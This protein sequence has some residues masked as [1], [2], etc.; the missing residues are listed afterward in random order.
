MLA[1]LPGP[2]GLAQL[3]GLGAALLALEGCTSPIPPGRSAVDAVEVHDA[4]GVAPDETTSKL[5]TAATPR[6]LGLFHAVY[7]YAIFDPATLQRDLARVER[8]YRGRGF[9]EAHARTARVIQ[10][11]S[12]H[13]RV[14]IVV[15]EGPP[16]LDR[17]VRVLGLDDVPADVKAAAESAATTALPAGTRFD[18]QAFASA[19]TAV[20][21]A[22]TD[23]GYAYAKVEAAAQVDLAAH[24]ADFTFTA[25]AGRACVFGPIAFVGLDPDGPGGAPPVI[26]EP[27]L[28]RAVHIREGATYSTAAIESATQALLDLEVLSAVEIVPTLADPPA[29]VVPLTVKVQPS[30]L[31]L[32]KAGAGFELDEIKTEVHALVGWEDHDFLGDLRDFSIDFKPGVVLYPTRVDNLVSPTNPLPAERLRLQLRQPGFLEPR[33]TLFVRPELNVYPLLVEPNPDPNQPVVGY[34]E[35]RGAVGVDRRFGKHFVA[36][37]SHNVQGEYPFAYIPSLPIA[38]PLPQ[39]LLSYP[40]LLTTFD[41][42]DDPVHP[43]AGL[44]AS[45]DLQVAG[46]GGSASDIRIQ[47]ELRGYVPLARSVTLALRGSLGL[48]FAQN[49]GD[50]VQHHL[51]EPAAPSPLPGAASRTYADVDRDIEIVYFRGFFSGGPS[52]NRGFPLRGIAPHGRVPFLNPASASAQVA[53]ACAPGQPG[54]DTPRCSVPIGGFTLWEGSIESRFDISGP[55]GAALF[56]DAGDVSAESLDFR[57]T[58]L[59]LSCGLGARYDTPVGPIRLD[60]GYR[61]PFLQVLGYATE[62]DVAAHDPTEGTQ[63]AIFGVP[64]ALAFGIGEAF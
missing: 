52:S 18:E 4:H 56:C 55:L 9:L 2:R 31:R 14:E 6:F 53:L 8:S 47:P 49:Y 33:S 63:P 23:H 20:S 7:D 64:L 38:E 17:T 21:R 54:Y 40:Q 44:Y 42:R 13:V 59:H 5:A 1:S 26:D 28:R 19:K 27:P 51:T 46:L 48:L 11:S 60:V 25:T 30:K 36:S 50:Y 15:D 43:H 16:T 3:V 57:P 34:V 35:P 24:A 61:I 39:I 62:A 10:V 45:N 58:H 41:L 37:I 12:N 32:F 29:E 22:L